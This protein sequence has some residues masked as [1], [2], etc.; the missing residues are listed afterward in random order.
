MGALRFSSAR[1]SLAFSTSC[2][3]LA[4]RRGDEE[5]ERRSREQER[6]K[7]AP[8]ALSFPPPSF[9]LSIGGGACDKDLSVRARIEGNARV[10]SQPARCD[11]AELRE[12]RAGGRP[13]LFERRG[14]KPPPP[15]LFSF[16]LT[17]FF[18]SLPSFSKKNAQLRDHDRAPTRHDR[19]GA[20]RRSS[21]SF[22]LL[23]F[24]LL[25]SLSPHSFPSSSSSS[26]SKKKNQK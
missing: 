5:R 12:E 11:E 25:S 2:F 19:G 18:P 3:S 1:D 17:L 24:L 14:E 16:H 10:S 13:P 23:I 22:L 21:S 15:P 6:K 4:P 8:V 20:V 26:K 9:A 7:N